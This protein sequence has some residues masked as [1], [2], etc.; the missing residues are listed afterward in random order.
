MKK[1]V[2]LIG[3]V[4]AFS[5]C[6][7]E[8]IDNDQIQSYDAKGKALNNHSSFAIPAISQPE[9]YENSI[10]LKIT[11]GSTGATGGISVRW[12]T[13]ETYDQYG[14]DNDLGCHAQ[15]TS[16]PSNDF[17]LDA[18]DFLLFNLEDYLNEEDPA[19]CNRQ[20]ECGLSYMFIVQ[21]HQDGQTGKSGYSEPMAFSTT[22][23]AQICPFG[24]GYWRNHSND[25][26]G[27]QGDS[28]LAT[29]Y[30][31]EMKL[32]DISYSRTQLN[33][34]LDMDNSEGNGL[35]NFSQHLIAAKLNLAIGVTMEGI[36]IAI[37]AADD[38][39]GGL[40]VGTHSF[41]NSEKSESQAIKE[42]I[43]EFNSLCEDDE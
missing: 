10:Q 18:N 21:A 4:L 40:V 36:D 23:C 19:D 24:K 16:N 25:N 5:G 26:P 17:G 9:L 34:I 38:L 13:K 2:Y 33:S 3:L 43:T 14:W 11:A 31:S 27:N 37:E 41:S 42:V 35:V 1:I 6:S 30:E 12:M 15:L 7:V 8:N 29:A 20:L 32:G 39:I 28:W 22:P